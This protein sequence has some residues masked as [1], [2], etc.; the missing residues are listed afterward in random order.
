MECTISSRRTRI[1][2]AKFKMMGHIFTK[3][4]LMGQV[5]HLKFLEIM[6]WNPNSFFWENLGFDPKLHVQMLM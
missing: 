2:S 6:I 5:L 1:F 3:S 4:E